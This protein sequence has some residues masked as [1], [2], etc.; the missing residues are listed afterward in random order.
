MKLLALLLT[1]S[2]SALANSCYSPTNDLE[3]VD[4]VCIDAKCR[5]PIT[6]EP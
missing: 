2:L 3:W 1:L 5:P 6:N 4:G